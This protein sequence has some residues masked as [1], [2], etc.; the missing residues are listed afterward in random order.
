MKIFK[1]INDWVQNGSE[2]KDLMII[3]LSFIAISFFFL[4]FLQ[5]FIR[6]FR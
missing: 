3:L 2:W 4:C 6:I 5:E 1:K